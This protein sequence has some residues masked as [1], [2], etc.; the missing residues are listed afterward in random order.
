MND[1]SL[2]LSCLKILKEENI[3]I[4]K[5]FKNNIENQEMAIFWRAFEKIWR[6]FQ[7]AVVAG[8][9]G[10]YEGSLMAS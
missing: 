3:K 2:L 5:T 7:A 1:Q 10:I 6:L 9:L 4:K 8:Y